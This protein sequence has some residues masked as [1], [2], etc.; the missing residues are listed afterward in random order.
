MGV[1]VFSVMFLLCPGRTILTYFLHYVFSPGR[2]LSARA[3]GSG[4]LW[5]KEKKSCMCDGAFP[6]PGDVLNI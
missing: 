4:V 5:P 3:F 2:F 1:A 6:L